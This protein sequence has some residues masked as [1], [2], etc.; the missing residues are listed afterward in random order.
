MLKESLSHLVLSAKVIS[1]YSKT[2]QFDLLVSTERQ[3]MKSAVAD[4]A[5]AFSLG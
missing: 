2:E 4:A 1:Y 3:Q 5:S